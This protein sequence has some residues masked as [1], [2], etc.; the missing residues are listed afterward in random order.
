MFNQQTKP[1][2]SPL[3]IGAVSA[4]LGSGER[5]KAYQPSHLLSAAFNGTEY[6]LL[7]LMEKVTALSVKKQDFEAV[8][9]I[10]GH[11][12]LDDI[13]II[14]MNESTSI[15]VC[16]YQVKYYQSPIAVHDFFNIDKPAIGAKTK[17]ADQKM[18]IGKFF[19]GWLA[20]RSEHEGLESKQLRSIVYTNTTVD[21]TLMNCISN[22]RFTKEFIDR[23]Q[24]ILIERNPKISKKVTKKF[25]TK[26]KIEG[27]ELT[28]HF[29]EKIWSVL[30]KATFLNANGE[31]TDGFIQGEAAL[32]LTKDDLPK[33]VRKKEVTDEIVSAINAK[34]LAKLK[35][36]ALAYQENQQDLWQLLY[37]EAFNYLAKKKEF[38]SIC[39]ES[40]EEKKQLFKKFLSSF[41]FQLEQPTL[42]ECVS[43]ILQNLEE[44]CEGTAE[45]VFCCLYYAIFEWFRNEKNEVPRLTRHVMEELIKR[46]GVCGQELFKLQG[47]SELTLDGIRCAYNEHFVDRAEASTLKEALKNGGLILVTGE[48]GIGKSTLVKQVLPQLEGYRKQYLVFA[49]ADLAQKAEL[50]QKLIEVLGLVALVNIIVID[51]AEALLPLDGLVLRDFIAKLTQ[52]NRRVVLTLH[53]ETTRHEAF[54]A[55]RT[56]ILLQPLEKSKVLNTFPKLESYKEIEQLIRLAQIPFY[57]GHIL[58]LIEKMEDKQFNA[59]VNSRKHELEGE[60]VKLVIEGPPEDG[61]AAARRLQWMT[62]AFKIAT[63]A[64]TTS[65]TYGISNIVSTK[66]LQCLI[67]ED[68]VIVENKNESEFYRFQHDL[69]FEHGLLTFLIKKWQIAAVQGETADFWNKLN[70]YQEKPSFTAALKKWLMIYGSRIREDM[71]NCIAVIAKGPYIKTILAVAIIT[72]EDK[73]LSKILE[74]TKPDLDVVFE[75]DDN[76]YATYLLLAIRH[77][78]SEAIKILADK[79]ASLY[80][81]RAGELVSNPLIASYRTEQGNTSSDAGTEEHE[82]GDAEKVAETLKAFVRQSTKYWSSFEKEPT[83]D[84]EKCEDSPSI[85]PEPFIKPDYDY[86]YIHQAA[87]HNCCASLDSL[88]KRYEKVEASAVINLQT[89]YQETPLHIAALNQAHEV[90][91]FLLDKG[92]GINLQDFWGETPLHNA[93]YQGDLEAAKMLLESYADPNCANKKGL[94]PCH[95]AIVRLDIEMVKLL[96]ECK[97][98]ILLAPCAGLKEEGYAC[99]ALD[100]LEEIYCNCSDHDATTNFDPLE[101]AYYNCFHPEATAKFIKFIYALRDIYSDRDRRDEVDDLDYFIT[102]VIGAPSDDNLD[103]S[104]ETERRVKAAI[105]SEDIDELEGLEDYI[106]S[107]PEVIEQLFESS[108]I[109]P[110]AETLIEKLLGN[111]TDSF[112]WKCGNLLSYAEEYGH[113]L[114]SKKIKNYLSSDDEED[115]DDE[116]EEEDE[117]DEEDECEETEDT[118]L[119]LSQPVAG[120]SAAALSQSLSGV[121]QPNN[122][123]ATPTPEKTNDQLHRLGP[124]K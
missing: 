64:T 1:R 111:I 99:T 95:I 25:F 34:V 5:P 69:L 98:E 101:E 100:L 105:F 50:R 76:S 24:P 114:L 72:K 62:L 48:K 19:R 20:W 43:A 86:F 93:V 18:H 37:D 124:R 67:D 70:E 2:S 117:E 54:K 77:D 49:A 15:E 118:S 94:T 109:F 31:L 8:V 45:Q 120:S 85:S 65:L 52:S 74:E 91:K 29:S 53:P 60:I 17:K 40:E 3:T 32:S 82:A 92:V 106:L 80:H 9:E 44:L 90:I 121:L 30:E 104:Q 7:V 51:G 116:E 89:E 81:P 83:Q 110:F 103:V 115:D 88:L 6:Q 122:A 39:K 46:A 36:I 26:L 11:G 108:E 87:L 66:S 10:Q 123:N 47:W 21:Q 16:S 14:L 42:E 97:G 71:L 58:S 78:N 75:Y 4:T 107:S 102:E 59:L 35:K 84:G 119:H 27:V 73:L 63:S 112:T 12:N 96:F 113:S 23:C 55:A 28:V 38:T 33:T 13:G 61:L 68:L 41:D 56:T 22:G 79:G 57:L